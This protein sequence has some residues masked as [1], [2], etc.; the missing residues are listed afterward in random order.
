[1][2]EVRRPK[3]RRRQYV[4]EHDEEIGMSLQISGHTGGEYFHINCDA[5]GKA[6]SLTDFRWVG[7]VPQV[8]AECRKC[9]ET[10]DFK[11]HPPTWL[12]IVPR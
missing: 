12:N 9:E 8:K 2:E 4:S 11:L 7:G 5:C 1:M 6:V 10:W 3:G